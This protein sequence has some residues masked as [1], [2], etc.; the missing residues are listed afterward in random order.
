ML[1]PMK[2]LGYAVCRCLRWKG[3]LIAVEPDPT[4]PPSNDRCFWCV[5]TQ[6]PIGP[7]GQLAE[8]ENCKPARDCYDQMS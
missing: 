6:A 3:M 2:D 8:P 5:H 1:E 7:D 4:V